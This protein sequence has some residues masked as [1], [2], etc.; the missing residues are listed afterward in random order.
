MRLAKLL[1]GLAMAGILSGA[2]IAAAQDADLTAVPPVPM[3]YQPE[4]TDWGEP[5]FRGGWPIDHLNGTPL[6]RAPEQGNRMF[7]TDEEMIAR[8]ARVNSYADRYTSEDTGNKLGHGHWVEMGEASRRTSLL[9]SPTNGRLPDMTD[10]GKRRSALMRSSWRR[11]QTFDSSLDFDSWDRCISRGLPASMLPMMY[12]NGI[13][14]FQAPGVVAIQMEMIH[15]TRIVYTDGRPALDSRI[16]NW[17]GESRGH[18][19]NGNT[20]VVETTNLQPGPSATNIVT[21]GSPPANDSPIS[22]EA[23][24]VERFTMTGDDAIVYEQTYHDPVV[25]AAPWT[26]RLNWKRNDKYGM[27]EYAC[28]EGNVQLRNYI[29]SSRALRVKAAAEQE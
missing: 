15:E 10:E 6:Q 7:L 12:N 3:D 4:T 20:L 26:V 16:L 8:E 23:K 18:W 22:L 11:G 24:M 29:S 25:F 19:E 1:G 28:H 17:I 5:D 2:S 14:I 27:Y 13:R 21:S 9:I